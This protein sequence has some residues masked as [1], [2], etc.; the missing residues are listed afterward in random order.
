[1]YWA[2]TTTPDFLVKPEGQTCCMGGN[3]MAVWLGG[4]PAVLRQIVKAPIRKGIY[5]G[6]I[7]GLAVASQSSFSSLTNLS[8]RM[9]HDSLL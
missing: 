2:V 9:C 5:P 8:M 1:M 6:L 3:R 7:P 4:Q